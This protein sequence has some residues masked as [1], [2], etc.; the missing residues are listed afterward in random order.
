MKSLPEIIT[1]VCE[2]THVPMVDAVFGKPGLDAVFQIM[3]TAQTLYKHVEPERISGQVIIFQT[4]STAGASPARP[5]AGPA[6]DFAALANHPLTDL[7]LE[8]AAGGLPYLRDPS[9]VTPEAFAATSVVYRYQAG[10][11]EFLAGSKRKSVTRL[12]PA[13]RSQFSVPTFHNLRDALQRYALENVRES[14][15]YIFR[16]V[17]H[18]KNRLFL[19]AKPESTMRDSLTQFLRNRLGGDHDVWPEQVVDESHPVDVRV[20]PRFLNNRLMLIE[21]KWLGFSVASDGHITAR[22]KEPRAQEG[23]NQ[24]AQYLDDQRRSAP[25]RVIQ[26]YYVIIDGRRENLAQGATTISR[27]DGMHFE[28]QELAFQPAPH[29]TRRDFD[30]PYRMFAAPVC[31]D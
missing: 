29:Q 8:V 20:Q 28:T 11:E 13:A 12:D 19:K 27:A 9:G 5:P 23:A 7:V 18:D 31:S 26:G 22:H 17:W 30:P 15:C 3:A 6:A 16:N 2:E 25:S 14:T 4:V 1:H 10:T 21:I 24:L